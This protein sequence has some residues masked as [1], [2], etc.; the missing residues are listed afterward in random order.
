VLSSYELAEPT[1]DSH[2]VTL[3]ASAAEAFLV[4]GTPKFAAQAIKKANEIGWKPL[5]LINFIS[6]SVSSTIVPAGPEKAVGI[7][8]GTITKDASDERWTDD[9]GIKWYRAH[10]E[11]YLS[12]ADIG[13]NNYVFGTQQ[14]QI[15]EQVLKQCGDDLSRENIVRQARNIRN[16]V[17]PTAMPGVVINT[18]PDSSMAY[19]QLQLQRWKGSSWEQF[20]EVLSADVK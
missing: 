14:G 5:F 20:G 18:G 12:G 2:V 4:A 16:L 10:F 1:I 7:I 19:T 13:D 3:K 9:P 15:L 17:L 6:S 11:K 8:A